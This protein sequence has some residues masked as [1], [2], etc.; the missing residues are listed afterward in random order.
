[1]QNWVHFTPERIPYVL[2]LIATICF[3]KGFLPWLKEGSIGEFNA[4][5]ITGV[6]LTALSSLFIF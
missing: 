3:F 6:I 5:F 2:I 1:M 4:G